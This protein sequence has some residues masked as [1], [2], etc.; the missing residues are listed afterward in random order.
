MP[1][2]LIRDI[3]RRQERAT[4]EEEEKRLLASFDTFSTSR[5][6]VRGHHHDRPLAQCNDAAQG[7]FFRTFE[8]G[9]L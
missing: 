6:D 2:D 5:K 7:R 1:R 8:K 9:K 4:E 3:E